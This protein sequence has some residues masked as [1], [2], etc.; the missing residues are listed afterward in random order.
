MKR[1]LIANSASGE[2]SMLAAA[3]LLPLEL[4]NEKR[5][6][7]TPSRFSRKYCNSAIPN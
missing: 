1:L 5:P 2:P 7:K 6:G 3:F 4:K